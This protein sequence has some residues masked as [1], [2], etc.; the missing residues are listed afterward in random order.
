[1]ERF[2]AEVKLSFHAADVRS[3]GEA[4]RRLQDAAR[5]AGFELHGGRVRAATPE[6]EATSEASYVPRDPADWSL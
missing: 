6:D 1:M 5:T 2:I 4:L 3:G